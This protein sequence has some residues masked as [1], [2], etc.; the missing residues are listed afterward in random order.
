MPSLIVIFQAGTSL[1][2]SIAP[3]IH[4]L[5]DCVVASTATHPREPSFPPFNVLLVYE[6][7][8]LKKINS[9]APDA[10]AFRSRGPQAN[11]VM[12][13]G[14]DKEEDNDVDH[15]RA[16]TQEFTKIIEATA[17]RTPTENENSFY[18]NYGMYQ[19]RCNFW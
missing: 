15:A 11:I 8:P 19:G 16:M 2:S 3:H 18:G 4:K 7:I 6:L 14:W 12:V 10:T 13:V 1:R 9:V 5:F 17:E